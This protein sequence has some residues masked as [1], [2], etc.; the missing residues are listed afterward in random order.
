[1]TPSKVTRVYGAFYDDITYDFPDGSVVRC[2][3]ER[4]I[5]T[6]DALRFVVDAHENWEKTRAD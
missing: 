4:K 1:M 5:S 6:E 3:L 2:Q